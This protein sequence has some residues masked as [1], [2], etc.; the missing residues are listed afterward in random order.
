[1]NA[2]KQQWICNIVD[3]NVIK[4]L[5]IKQSSAQGVSGGC[6]LN[7]FSVAWIFDEN[8]LLVVVVLVVVVVVIVVV[9]VVV[10]LFPTEY[11]QRSTAYMNNNTKNK[12]T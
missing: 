3:T 2:F 4:M 9:V 1:M 12:T 11:E 7:T 10:I 5:S 6:Y 8:S